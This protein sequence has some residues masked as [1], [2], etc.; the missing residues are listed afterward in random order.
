MLLCQCNFYLWPCPPGCINYINYSLYYYYLCV[1]WVLGLEGLGV[2][3]LGWFGEN[4]CFG[5]WSSLSVCAFSC[6]SLFTL[7][8]FFCCCWLS[9]LFGCA[10]VWLRF[11]L[12]FGL[13]RLKGR[14]E[15]AFVECI[16]VYCILYSV[17]CILCLVIC[18]EM[19]IRCMNIRY[20]W[21]LLGVTGCC[22]LCHVL[23]CRLVS[24]LTL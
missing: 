10:F 17:F 23:S 11:L 20:C 9:L 16:P 5:A 3:G 15:C 2:W 19:C 6:S 21:V 4:R 7:F 13:V 1:L 12:L 8:F 14:R 22:W 18:F 24:S